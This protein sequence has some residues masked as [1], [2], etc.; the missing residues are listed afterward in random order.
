MFK[1][2]KELN[3]LENRLKKEVADIEEN[4]V[5]QKNPAQNIEKL[6]W[7]SYNKERSDTN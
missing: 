1:I 6:K 3:M 2:A 7:T 4:M 5:A